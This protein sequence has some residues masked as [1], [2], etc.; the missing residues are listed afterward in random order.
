MQLECF[1][2]CHLHFRYVYVVSLWSCWLNN[3]FTGL[4]F[5]LMKTN[6]DLSHE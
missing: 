6:T 3:R 5:H 4:R 1:G 2:A